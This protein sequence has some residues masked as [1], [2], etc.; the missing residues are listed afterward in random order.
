MDSVRQDLLHALR[1]LRK[2]PGFTAVAVACLAIGIGA[3]TTIFTVLNGILLR[4]LPVA[5]PREAVAVFTS[6]F[7]GS[8]YG[9]SSFPDYEDFRRR[10]DALSGLVLYSPAPVAL[11]TKGG[12]E[13]LF[14]ELATANYFDVVGRPPAL[15]RGF[16]T[17]EDRPGAAPVAVIGHGLWLRLFGGDPG[18]LGRA[19]VLGG[20][21][22]EIVGVAPAGFDGLTRGLAVD[23]WLPVGAKERLEPG[24]GDLSGRGSRSWLLLGR[25]RPGATLDQAQAQLDVVAADLFRA[26][27]DPWRRLEGGGR[28]VTVVPEWRARIHPALL[29]PVLGFLALLLVVV[30]LVLLIACANL[31][32]LLLARAASRTREI[33][34]RTALGASRARLLRQLLTESV[35]LSLAGGAAGLLLAFWGSGLLAALPP[36][37]P[38]PVRLDLA[39]DSTVLGFTLTLSLVTGLLFGLAPALAASRGDVVGA[40]KEGALSTSSSPR[41]SRVRGA[42]VVG[43]VAVSLFLLVGSGLFL[44]SLG[45]ARALDLGFDPAGLSLLS[46]D[47]ELGGYDAAGGRA[48]YT[49][50]LERAR[51]L[52]SVESATLT[53]HLPLGLG[54]SRRRATIDGYVPRPGEDME[55]ATSSVG[56]DYFRTLRVPIVRGRALAEG[57]GEAAPRVIVVNEAFVRRYWPGQDPIGRRFWFGD[58]SGPPFQVVGVARDGKYF[59]LGEV[60]R[61]FVFTSIQQWYGGSATLLV[62]G[63]PGTSLEALRRELLSLDPNL[64]VFDPKSM[65]Q[66]LGLALLPA[67]LAATLLGGFGGLALLLAGLG[68]YGLMAYVVSQRRREVGIRMALGADGGRVVRLVVSQGMRLAAVGMAAGLG[69]AAALAPA[70]G[71][72]LYGIGPGDTVSFLSATALLG[73]VALLACYVPARRATRV[74]PAIV[75]RCE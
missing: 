3:N 51:R 67:S 26:Y 27:P 66:H 7:S 39:P 59:T 5:A 36:P 25:L 20:H 8:R 17:G 38:V 55:V 54:H 61:P 24:T 4:P 35:L 60:P 64:P 75:L 71:S 10:A 19:V 57:D 9:A 45:H 2:S 16:S 41:V 31:A 14:A 48:M 28:A 62:R 70:V 50:I 15:G 49:R 47:L 42:L 29:G 40:L 43:Q 11:T 63:G 22:F 74:D 69:T 12:V 30:A 34:V 21:P 13:R 73:A 65:E 33:S 53:R 68:L 32:S 46:V 37:L 6:D 58:P 56:S 44:R 18:V 72:L 23:L 52:P 1:L